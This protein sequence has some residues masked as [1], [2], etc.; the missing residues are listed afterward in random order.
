MDYSNIK[1]VKRRIF[2]SLLFILISFLVYG[3]I[4]HIFYQIHLLL[5]WVT[6]IA[7]GIFVC[8]AWGTIVG[9]NSSVYYKGKI[10]FLEEDNNEMRKTMKK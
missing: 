4:S 9:Y 2:K 1:Y 6:I 10:K 7:I 5:R 8:N 3:A